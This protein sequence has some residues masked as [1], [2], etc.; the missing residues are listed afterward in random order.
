MGAWAFV[1]C[2]L[3]DVSGLAAKD[4]RP[5]SRLR[6]DL[7]LDSLDAVELLVRLEDALGVSVANDQAEA[8]VTARDLVGLVED[9]Q[10]R[11]TGS[12]AAAQPL[13]GGHGCAE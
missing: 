13:R 7:C 10:Q 6:E 11:L 12:D 9:L 5:T 4:I 1:V 3:A 8:L 2:Q